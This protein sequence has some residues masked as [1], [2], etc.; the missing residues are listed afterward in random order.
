MTDIANLGFAIDSSQ[1]VT[2]SKNLD[3]MNRSSATAASGS[4]KLMR[5]SEQTAMSLKKMA[6]SANSAKNIILGLVGVSGMGALASQIL[7]ASNAM[8]GFQFGLKAALGSQQAAAQAM[9]FV[10]GE[11]QRLGI[12]LQA[13]A[14]AFTSL[15]AAA[16]GTAL[17]G[18]GAQK[19]FSAVAEASR[20]L[21]LST[22]QTSGALNA[23]QQMMSKGN[24]QAEELRGQLGERLPGAFNLAAKAMGVT[25]Q[26]LNKML[27]DGKVLATD[28]LPKLADEL[29][30]VYGAQ[31]TD[32]ANSPA[33]ALA[34]L[35]NA[36]FEL[37]V[38]IGNAGFLDIIAEGAKTLKFVL[39]QVT[40]SMKD[41]VVNSDDMK[42]AA[43]GLSTGIKYLAVA[44]NVTKNV[45]EDFVL[46]IAA[47]V[48]TVGAFGRTIMDVFGGITNAAKAGAMAQM[49]QF[50]AANQLIEKDRKSVV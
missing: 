17:E 4:E 14:Q 27:D 42:I 21:H 50:D 33:A 34:R 22:E 49:G 37:E 10:R 36:V 47:S 28:L 26:Q 39:D 19:I 16:R 9:S 45:I 43:E 24:V 15:A 35:K 2:A 20:V 40:A 41:G 31:A 7:S 30:K 25:T 1:A 13:S 46:L 8:A 5:Q 23:I 6:D 12:D 44:F 48:T 29:H 11:A 32:A 38:A 3:G 18:A